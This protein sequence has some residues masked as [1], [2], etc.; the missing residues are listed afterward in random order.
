VINKVNA[1]AQAAIQEVSERVRA[2]N[3]RAVLVCAA[4]LLQLEDPQL[5]TGK[6]ALIVED[7]PTITHGGMAYG[8]GYAAAVAAAAAEIVDPRLSATFDLRPIFDQY[9]HIGKVLPAMGYNET[10]LAA[11]E[12]TIN[13]AQADVVVAGTPLD[14][15]ALLKVNKPIVR[16]RYEFA[17]AGEPTLE[18]V[19]DAFLSR[20]GVR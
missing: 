16:V 15:A 13:R 6:R 7:G 3:P 17:E 4:S 14:L 20:S 19:V 18:S 12:A 9:P 8:A 10:Q 11:L 1:A 5:V 2:V